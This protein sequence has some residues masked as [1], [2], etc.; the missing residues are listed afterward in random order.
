MREYLHTLYQF[1]DPWVVDD[2]KFGTAFGIVAT[3]LEEAL[4][5]TFEWFRA[6][7]AVRATT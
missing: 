7:A 6:T 2:A 3:P 5:T 4:D 1:T